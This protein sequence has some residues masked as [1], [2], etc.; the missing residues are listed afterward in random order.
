MPRMKSKNNYEESIP[1]TVKIVPFPLSER[2][3][4]YSYNQVPTTG[5][6][7]IKCK[8]NP[9]SKKFETG[10]EEDDFD[11]LKKSHN[12]DIEKIKSDLRYDPEKHTIFWDL[13][14]LS[15]VLSNV[16]VTLRPRKDAYDF[17]KW[18]YL[19]Y[20]DEVCVSENDRSL[21]PK[22]THYIYSEKEANIEKSN[23]IQQKN[24]LIVAVHALTLDEKRD[25]IMLVNK[26]YVGNASNEE[27][28]I[29]LENLMEKNSLALRN[30]IKLNTAKRKVRI[31]FLKGR[32]H[33]IILKTDSGYFVD[34]DFLGKTKDEVH[35][36]L[37]QEKNSKIYLKIEEL[38]K[39]K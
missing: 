27:I 16:P 35:D 29:K 2:K 13:S 26:E 39:D 12:F 5:T 17:I 31:L 21:K 9:I 22:A 24:D 3:L 20:T 6:V 23:T 18:K 10:L 1:E 37:M 28:I 14:M 36:F 34:K 8:L 38:I 30:V 15:T 11:Y 4:W 19:K 32:F 7:T 25:V 33:E